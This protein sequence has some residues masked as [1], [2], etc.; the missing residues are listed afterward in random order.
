MTD[1]LRS[2]AMF[3]ST[4]AVMAALAGACSPAPQASKAEPVPAAP[5]AST[6]APATSSAPTSTAATPAAA[7]AP[8]VIAAKPVVVAAPVAAKPAAPTPVSAPAPTPRPQAA[9][10]PASVTRIGG[11]PDTPGRATVQRVC[12]SCHS[13]GMV[14]AQGRTEDEWADVIGRM[15]NNGLQAS[16]DD[17]QTVH[18]YL[19]RE[20]PKK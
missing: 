18:A 15:V 17:L 12:S 20:F 19:S 2:K 11:L 7:Q 8:E 1:T 9:T 3:L 13:I 5:A 6:P 10:P 4:V 16:D 14:T